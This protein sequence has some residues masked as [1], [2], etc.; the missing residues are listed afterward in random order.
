[1]PLKLFIIHYCWCLYVGSSAVG[2]CRIKTIACSFY[3][4]SSQSDNDVFPIGKRVLRFNLKFRCSIDR[5]TTRYRGTPPVVHGVRVA[6]CLIFYV[7]LS[8][9][10]FVFF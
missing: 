5:D 1:M 8:V 4:S 6:Y 3:K 7:V 2:Q 10:G 9:F